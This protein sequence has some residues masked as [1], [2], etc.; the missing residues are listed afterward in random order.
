MSDALTSIPNAAALQ[1]KIVSYNSQINA[2]NALVGGVNARLKALGPLA[3]K[4]NAQVA[5]MNGQFKTLNQQVTEANTLMTKLNDKAKTATGADLAP[6]VAQLNTSY[7]TVLVTTAQVG[8]SVKTLAT[9]VGA[10][11]ST[12]A[13]GGRITA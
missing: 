2:T 5:T 4:Y 10:T 11:A 9:T 8:I 3:P 12:D 13:G 1:S 7:A 6:L